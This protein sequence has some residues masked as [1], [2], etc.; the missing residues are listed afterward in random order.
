MGD[1]LEHTDEG[2]NQVARLRAGMWW[3]AIGS[4]AALMALVSWAI[5]SAASGSGAGMIAANSGSVGV[6]LAW[7]AGHTAIT[8]RLQQLAISEDG[9]E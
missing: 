9:R 6:V 5:L 2:Q 8:K 7:V 4:F 3:L 1:D